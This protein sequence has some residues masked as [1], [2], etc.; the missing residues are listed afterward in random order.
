MCFAYLMLLYESKKILKQ[1]NL[2]LNFMGKKVFAKILK[3]PQ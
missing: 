3:L 2:H 1:Y